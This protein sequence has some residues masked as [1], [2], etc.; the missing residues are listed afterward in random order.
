MLLFCNNLL[1]LLA[2]LHKIRKLCSF[3]V[4]YIVK[5]FVELMRLWAMKSSFT[6][7]FPFTF[8]FLPLFLFYRESTFQ[9]LY[10]FYIEIYWY[11]HLFFLF[12]MEAGLIVLLNILLQRLIISMIRFVL[13]GLSNFSKV[14]LILPILIIFHS[15]RLI[16]NFSHHIK[17]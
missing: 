9:T 4:I 3:I 2:L 13:F 8:T 17:V 12:L 16:L 15:V 14:I 1:W 6:F 7:L 5:L 10:A 11:T